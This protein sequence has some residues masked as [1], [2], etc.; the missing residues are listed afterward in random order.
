MPSDTIFN[1]IEFQLAEDKAEQGGYNL[2]DIPSDVGNFLGTAAIATVN[3][4]YNTG[5]PAPP[6]KPFK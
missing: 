3:G 5:L 2:A 4:F 6:I 1:A